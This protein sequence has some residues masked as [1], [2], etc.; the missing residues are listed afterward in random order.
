MSVLGALV[1]DA[2]GAF[3]KKPKVPELPTIDPTATQQKTVAGNLS[4]LPDIMQLGAG[5]NLFNQQQL[6]KLQE[7]ALPGG[8]A[9]GQAN[10]LAMLKGELPADVARAVTR[11]AA[12]RAIAG[13]FGGSQ[14]AGSLGLRDLGI[15][16]LQ[17]MQQGLSAAERWMAATTAQQ[18]NITSMFFTP[19]QRLGFEM[20]DRQ[21][22]FQRD[23]LAAQVAAAPDPAKAA[24][25]REL[26]RMFN[27][28][29]QFGMMAAGGAM[30]GG[31]GGGGGMMGGGGGGMMM[32]GGGSNPWL[33]DSTSGSAMGG[34]LG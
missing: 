9:Q 1:G 10:I 28:F 4:N 30:P 34:T 7:M 13:G 24:L 14:L 6:M 2:I 22:R 15:T 16:S 33:G 21:Q 8:L 3:G 18:F 23:S 32:G 11:S 20:D 29:A 31:G 25:G 26:D 5:V 19:Q 27:T 17:T 12:G